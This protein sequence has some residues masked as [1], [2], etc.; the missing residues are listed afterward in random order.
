M[1]DESSKLSDEDKAKLDALEIEWRRDGRAAFE[2]FA[3]KDPVAYFRII[4]AI[5]PKAARAA[6][7]DALIEGG[8]TNADIRALAEKATYKN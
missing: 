4:A 8:L 3:E 7:E 6:I 1:G 5:N 2:R